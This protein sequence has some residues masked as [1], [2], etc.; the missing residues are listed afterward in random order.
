MLRTSKEKLQRCLK[1]FMHMAVAS[2][3][4]VSQASVQA[5][6]R[7]LGATEL[8][9]PVKIKDVARKLCKYDGGTDLDLLRELPE[10]SVHQQEYLESVC[11]EDW[12]RPLIELELGTTQPNGIYVTPINELPIVQT[13]VYRLRPLLCDSSVPELDAHSWQIAFQQVGN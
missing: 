13:P 11:D 5:A 3:E 6:P 7:I 4:S 8:A 2:F 10:L 12:R 9:E 1:Q